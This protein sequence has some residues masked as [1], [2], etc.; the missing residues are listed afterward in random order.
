MLDFLSLEIEGFVDFFCL[1]KGWKVGKMEC[2]KQGRLGNSVC[3]KEN[4]NSIVR[5]RKSKRQTA[6]EIHAESSHT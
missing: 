5:S 4:G 2:G 6:S 1:W 3:D